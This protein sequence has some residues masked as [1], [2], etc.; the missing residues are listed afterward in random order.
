MRSS[1]AD[2][3]FR[4]TSAR[5]ERAERAVA[6]ARERGARVCGRTPAPLCRRL[7]AQRARVRDPFVFLLPIG[8]P[9]EGSLASTVSAAE[10]R[11]DGERRRRAGA[12]ERGARHVRRHPHLCLFPRTSRASPRSSSLVSPRRLAGRERGGGGWTGRATRCK[13][14]A[15]WPRPRAAHVPARCPPLPLLLVVVCVVGS[16]L[17]CASVCGL[18]VGIACRGA[19]RRFAVSP[20]VVASSPPVVGRAPKL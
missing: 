13:C 5:N 6:T 18:F 10:R 12:R 7:N 2:W 15:V 3:R 19:P 17:R 14:S 8:P 11:W 4:D 9:A 16:G 20:C 1:I